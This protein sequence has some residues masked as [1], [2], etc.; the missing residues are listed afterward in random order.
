MANEWFANPPANCGVKPSAADANKMVF[1]F[2]GTASWLSLSK[3]QA[4]KDEKTGMTGAPKFGAGIFM[5][6]SP[7][8]YQWLVMIAA[9]AVSQK[10]NYPTWEALVQVVTVLERQNKLFFSRSEALQKTD[11]SFPPGGGP[12]MIR[13]R[14][15]L[16]ERTK[17]GALNTPALFDN[18]GQALTLAGQPVNEQLV[19]HWFYPGGEYKLFLDPWFMDEAKHPGIWGSLTAM[20]FWG[21]GSRI[22]LS[23]RSRIDPDAIETN[24]NAAPDGGPAP[25]ALTGAAP[26]ALPGTS[27]DHLY[28]GGPKVN[29]PPAVAPPPTAVPLAQTPQGNTSLMFGGSAPVQNAHPAIVPSMPPAVAAPVAVPAGAPSVMPFGQTAVPPWQQ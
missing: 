7:E 20:Q 6:Y 23:G 18:N 9:H 19:D 1:T 22:V 10:G 8:L 3:A 15:T 29:A 2:I 12:N 11:G 27:A 17:R 4:M 16:Q 28:G 25:A 21:A 13:V 5:P 24:P 26:G 14:A